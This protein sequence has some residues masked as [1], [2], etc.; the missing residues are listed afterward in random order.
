MLKKLFLFLGILIIQYSQSQ[1]FIHYG[2]GLNIR[3]FYHQQGI[4]Y[5]LTASDSAKNIYGIYYDTVTSS[6]NYGHEFS[7]I[8]LQIFNGITWLNTKPIKIYSKHTLDA[9]RI[10]DIKFIHGK[11]WIAGSFDSTENNLGAGVLVFNG[12]DWQS[13]NIN[14]NQ[15]FPDYF[16]VRQILSIKNQIVLTGNFDTMPGIRCN[17]I[18]YFNGFS[19]VPIGNSPPYGFNQV[20]NVGNVFF[21]QTADSIYAFNKNKISPDS[22]DISNKT[23]RKLAVL[24]GN[25]FEQL[26]C[27]FSYIGA[28]SNYLGQLVLLPSSNLV[29]ISSIAVKKTS[30]WTIYNLGDSFYATNYLGSF[31]ANKDLYFY[32]QNPNLAQIEIYKFDGLQIRKLKSFKVS[33]QYINLELNEAQSNTVI[34]GLFA[35]IRQ[36]NYLKRVNQIAGI[37]FQD[38]AIVYGISFEDINK[39][40]IKQATEN[41]LPN[42]KIYD[43][44]N[45]F[46]CNSN[47]MGEFELELSSGKN[48]QIGANNDFGYESSFNYPLDGVKDS[49][50]NLNIGLNRSNTSDVSIAV[51]GHTAKKAKQGFRTRYEIQI[52]NGSQ[53]PFNDQ[54]YVKHNEKISDLI[55]ENFAISNRQKDGFSALVNV[56]SNGIVKLVFSCIYSVDSFS[57]YDPVTIAA[58]IDFFDAKKS[59]N[60][61]TL[62]QIVVSAFDPNIKEAN[63]NELVNVDKEINYIIWFQNEGNDTALNVCVV[64]SFGSLFSLKDI[65]ITGDSKGGT[66]IPEVKNNCLIWN[67]RHILLPPKSSDSLGSIGFVSFRVKLNDKANIGDT[68]YNKASIYFDYQKPIITNKAKV[69]FSKN[70]SVSHSNRINH[71][72]FGP[73]PNSGNLTIKSKMEVAMFVEIINSEGKMVYSQKAEQSFVDLIL[74]EHLSNG[75]YF[76][77]INGQIQIE[78][79]L[80]L[81]R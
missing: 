4:N 78:N 30:N 45:Q 42:C 79:P 39:D 33:N 77:R 46:L 70:T 23:Y 57:L 2:D 51:I 9:P 29:Y 60:F 16:E 62:S 52:R 28:V 5:Y 22:F 55:F 19:W 14:L 71:F 58:N 59:N 8:R 31:G 1:N 24:R 35:E 49:L 15:V 69:Y 68:I 38:K 80:V 81:T 26:T 67:F 73:N 61:D 75:I 76:I 48:Y 66:I 47:A 13:A 36:G 53:N 37:A 3:T 12:I 32:F 17:G 34:S 54:L 6:F 44:Q 21:K 50:Y 18:V 65:H 20:S 56:E 25:Q 64:D 41:I 43:N 74:P 27:P 63:P 7:S 40:G 10:L 11:V 72:V